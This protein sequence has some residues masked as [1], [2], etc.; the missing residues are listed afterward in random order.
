MRMDWPGRAALRRAAVAVS[1]AIALTSTL[2]AKTDAEWVAEANAFYKGRA[3]AVVGES[4]VESELFPAMV[5]MERPPA[6]VGAPL[7]AAIVVPGRPEWEGAKAWAQGSLQRPA[8]DALRVVGAPG[9]GYR[10]TQGYGADAAS[11]A[12][13]EAGLYTDLGEP[14]MLA[15]ARFE[16]LDRLDDLASLVQVEATRLLE[17]GRGESAGELL[18]AWIRLAR[19]V[20]DREMAIEME[21]GMRALIIGA[22]RLLDIVHVWP[23]A[24]THEDVKAFVEGLDPASLAV[25]RLT[26]P[27]A[28]V[29]AGRQLV[30]RA[31]FERGGPNPETFG[32]TMARLSSSQ[33]PLRMFGEAARW[34]DRAAQQ[35]DVFDQ[36]D[37]IEA[38]QS[39]LEYRW[40]LDRFDALQRTP[41]VL[42]DSP[43]GGFAPLHVAMQRFDELIALRDRLL[44]EMAGTRLALGVAA[45][46]LRYERF[47]PALASI[48]PQFVAEIERDP[49]SAYKGRY[50]DYLY[51][52]PIRDEPRTARVEPQPHRIQVTLP[53]FGSVK[54]D[55]AVALR[56]LPTF[57]EA[58]QDLALP[59][60]MGAEARDLTERFWALTR[61]TGAEV[62][63]IA[64][65]IV[66]A[67]ASA[68]DSSAAAAM[69][70]SED[71]IAMFEGLA[72]DSESLIAELD[73]LP[74]ADR[75]NF[76]EWYSNTLSRYQRAGYLSAQSFAGGETSGSD[77]MSKV[78]STL[79]AT[80]GGQAGEQ[81]GGL[82]TF[83][84]HVDDTNFIL[85]SAG[86]D[87]K[88]D[89]VAQAGEGATDFLIWPPLVSLL[90]ERM[91]GVAAE[92]IPGMWIEYSPAPAPETLFDPPTE[93]DRQQERRRGRRR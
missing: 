89:R 28:N 6:S 4:R 27:R 85:A 29:I 43:Q 50:S 69:G 83:V 61:R 62:V 60:S 42:D 33:N 80:P 40:N 7:R 44:V 36:T 79:G 82:S 53:Q 21:W 38:A 35:A 22:E 45:Y 56:E 78:I 81:S 54:S 3:H 55:P 91:G 23:D 9:S 14:P 10:L 75:E 49:W 76:E 20:A 12:L 71:E 64:E 65:R 93:E 15:G 1:A 70:P 52:V 16:Y 73:N 32:A 13:V 58:V 72:S 39:D 87:T 34:Q 77:F 74:A 31:F 51:F 8:L 90:R 19:M 18:L 68:E 67:V 11:D 88:Q 17:E 5:G 92:A 46:T 47:P 26:P 84:V 66:T 63:G 41:T 57:E 25:D 37:A 2:A 30:E 24:M 86:P 48:R 59:E